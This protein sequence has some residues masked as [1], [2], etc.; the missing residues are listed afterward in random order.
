L[1]DSEPRQLPTELVL[2]RGHYYW[3]GRS[4]RRISGADDASDGRGELATGHKSEV[5]GAIETLVLCGACS[6]VIAAA[7]IPWE[8]GPFA[9]IVHSLTL[10]PVLLIDPVYRRV[11]SGQIDLR[12]AAGRAGLA[13]RRSQT[14]RTQQPWWLRAVFFIALIL[15]FLEL[16][17][18]LWGSNPETRAGGT[19]VGFWLLLL[20]IGFIIRH[21]ARRRKTTLIVVAVATLPLVSAVDPFVPHIAGIGGVYNFPDM[22]PVEN[23]IGNSIVALLASPIALAFAFMGY[24]LASLV[25]RLRTPRPRPADVPTI[26]GPPRFSDDGKWWWDGK[27]WQPAV[28]DDGRLR[29]SGTAWMPVEMP[30]PKS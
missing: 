7:T 5:A 25:H 15:V 2:P 20:P 22:S 23:A 1:S 21:S 6:V 4:L 11:S 17:G 10:L 19:I 27:Q 30:H 24:G 12:H 14:A 3:D 29:W 9:G 8:S 28:S 16:G 13:L 26:S 18:S